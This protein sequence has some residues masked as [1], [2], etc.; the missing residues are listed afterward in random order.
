M[1]EQYID[2]VI[3]WLNDSNLEVWM[4]F[5]HACELFCSIVFVLISVF[6]ITKLPYLSTVHGNL[7]ILLCCIF[8]TYNI[9]ALCRVSLLST[10]TYNS[11]VTVVV[12]QTLFEVSLTSLVL[13]VAV[14]RWCAKKF[15]IRYENV[16][17]SIGYMVMFTNCIICIGLTLSFYC[18]YDQQQSEKAD[19]NSIYK[20][21][22]NMVLHA[23]ISKF[24]LSFVFFMWFQMCKPKPSETQN[25]SA[26]TSLGVKYQFKE[27]VVTCRALKWVYLAFTLFS[28]TTLPLSVIRHSAIMTQI[29]N[30]AFEEILNTLIQCLNQLTAIACAVVLT[31]CLPNLRK[32]VES[33]ISSM[34]P[35][36]RSAIYASV[37]DKKLS[38]AIY[39]TK[40][41]F[42][43]LED[44]W[45]VNTKNCRTVTSQLSYP[46]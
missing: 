4:N 13:L 40:I 11:K 23:N 18:K 9:I 35:K 14:E 43:T 15:I 26:I 33:S 32:Q 45:D 21:N 42:Q 41:H 2:V 27:N 6:M 17:Y 12:L 24:V 8:F 39:D 5:L 1:L 31:S 44:I 36:K 34:L 25:F 28:L 22:Y 16:P 10:Q 46:Y 29:T 20:F 38:S 19:R 3:R 7:R 37:E 30:P